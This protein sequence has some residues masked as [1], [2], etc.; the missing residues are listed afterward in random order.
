MKRVRHRALMAALALI[1][2]EPPP[3]EE[4]ALSWIHVVLPPG[5]STDALTWEPPLTPRHDHRVGA[6]SR[7]LA[8]EGETP[9]RFEAPGACPAPVP[10]GA[11]HLE[12]APWIRVAEEPLQAGF[13]QP[14]TIEILPGCREAVAGTI[15]WEHIGGPELTAR[16]ETRRG[17]LVS[18]ITAPA[19][20]LPMPRP[21]GVIPISP[22]T[23]GETVLRATWEGSGAPTSI[24]RVRVRA[25]ARSSGLPSVPLGHRIYLG[26]SGW[27]VHRRPPRARASVEPTDPPSLLVDAP[28]EWTL[29]DSRG[30][31]LTLRVGRYDETALDCGRSSCHASA[32]E[33]VTTSPMTSAFLR[34]LDRTEDD[35]SCAFEC[36]VLGEEGVA[37]GGFAHVARELGWSAGDA[38]TMG[39]EQ[40]P[41]ALRRASGVG[42]TACHG[43][44]AIPAPE[45]RWAILASDVCATC[46]DAPP[47][48]RRVEQWRAGAMARADEDPATR[49]GPCARCHTTE[50]FLSSLGVRPVRSVPEHA[51]PLGVACAA[52]HA[53]HGDHGDSLLRSVPL[54]AHLS[55]VPEPSRICVPC[56]AS[57]P[58]DAVGPNTAALL[59]APGAGTSL[60]PHAAIDRGCLGCHTD[61]SFAARDD[62]CAAC[63]AT[64]TTEE[65]RAEDARV[66][67]RAEALWSELSRRGAVSGRPTHQTSPRILTT[68]PAM[69]EAA[70]TLGWVLADPA[71]TAHGGPRARAI[72]EAA[73]RAL[74]RRGTL[75]LPGPRRG[76]EPSVAE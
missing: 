18:G 48:Y 65:R 74:E 57:A 53:P 3:A 54:P 69:V 60:S 50:G 55:G 19:D 49:E 11:D 35:L 25:A 40:M 63:H 62:L 31:P 43:P 6:R 24:L 39:W 17:F 27:E 32:S 44:G 33:G 51:R 20:L 37:D 9:S 38:L 58:E 26:G 42:C 7:S 59:Y 21:F 30:A 64:S 67:A 13:E 8:F 71:P 41:S 36:H 16:T 47:R 10:P 68:D 52:C 4:P 70:R 2:C 1:A 28:G 12:L 34:A 15:R 46:H 73:R 5:I 23:R 61:H 14:V 72:V 75:A 22:R 29:T 56:H 66:R 45:A 76:G